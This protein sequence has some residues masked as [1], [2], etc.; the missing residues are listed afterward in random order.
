MRWR[1]MRGNNRN[2]MVVVV[3]EKTNL[4]VVYSVTIHEAAL[5]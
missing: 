5:K 4:N 3:E 2:V 1:M